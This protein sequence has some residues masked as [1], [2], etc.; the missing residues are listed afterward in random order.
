MF[1][2]NS[3]GRCRSTEET[4]KLLIETRRLCRET[5]ANDFLFSRTLGFIRLELFV[6]TNFLGQQTILPSRIAANRVGLF[7][8]ADVR[9]SYLVEHP[10]AATIY[11]D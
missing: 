8:T 9:V 11:G 4:E 2:R 7:I 3:L 10:T 6:L 1:K 5:R